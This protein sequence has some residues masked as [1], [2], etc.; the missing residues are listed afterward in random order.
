[1]VQWLRTIR[2]TTFA[3]LIALV[4]VSSGST[5]SADESCMG[6]R[7][8]YGTSATCDM[9]NQSCNAIHSTGGLHRTVTTGLTV[10]RRARRASLATGVQAQ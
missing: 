6:S 9:A 8:T 10:L 2:N 4:I 1:M 5:A 3:G 7:T